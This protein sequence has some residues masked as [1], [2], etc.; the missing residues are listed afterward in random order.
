[1]ARLSILSILVLIFLQ[2]CTQLVDWQ[3]KYPDNMLEE[4]IEDFIKSN[5]E[6]DI[7]LTPISGDETQQF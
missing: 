5:T 4:Y 6:K 1:M 7:D 2:S 3:T